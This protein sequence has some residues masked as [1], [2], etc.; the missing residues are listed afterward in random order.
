MISFRS[1]H[2]ILR[3][4]INLKK[5]DLRG[6]Q[7]FSPVGIQVHFVDMFQSR[8]SGGSRGGARGVRTPP[9]ILG[10]KRRND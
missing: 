7:R 9:L 4:S 8:Y 10:K 5:L 6:L 3:T 2:R 1:N